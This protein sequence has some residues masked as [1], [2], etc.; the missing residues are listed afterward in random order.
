PSVSP[1]SHPTP[2][3]TPRLVLGY[4]CLGIHIPYLFNIAPAHNCRH[5]RPRRTDPSR[6]PGTLTLIVRS[7]RLG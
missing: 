6:L 7:D 1:S 5:C 3:P 4:S 2:T